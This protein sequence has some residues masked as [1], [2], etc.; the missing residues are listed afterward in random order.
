MDHITAKKQDDGSTAIIIEKM[1]GEKIELIVANE[2]DGHIVY[3]DGEELEDGET[4]VIIEEI[5]PSL[6]HFR[7]DADA[8]NVWFSE[9][10]EDGNWQLLGL[11]EEGSEG[12]TFRELM[13][14]HREERERLHEEMRKAREQMRFQSAE[15]RER[16]L[17]D[18]KAQQDRIREQSTEAMEQY[19]EQLRQNRDERKQLFED[20]NFKFDTKGNYLFFSPGHSGIRGNKNSALE[21][22]LLADGLIENTANYKFELTG[23]GLLKVNGKKQPAAAY[24]KYRK[25]WEEVSG[26]KIQEK[27]NIQINKRS[28]A[29]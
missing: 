15:E 27:T 9:P 20:G 16:L 13:E 19:R 6:F 3:L 10:D 23:K 24:E 18:L 26:K 1:D 14:R 29:D 4:K 5:S 11:G 25:L 21:K 22:Q 2:N 8:P 7:S 28:R 12:A 17:N